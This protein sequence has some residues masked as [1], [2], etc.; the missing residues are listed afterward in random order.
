MD[1]PQ[2]STCIVC[3]K[4][5]SRSELR[6]WAAVR[7]QISQLIANDF[8]DWKDGA[9]IWLADLSKYRHA[10][11]ENL[12]QSEQGELGALEQQVLSSFETGETIAAR[13]EDTDDDQVGFGDR[14]ADH[15][16]RFGGSWAFILSFVGVLTLWMVLNTTAWL[17]DAFDPFPFILLNLVLSCVAALQAPIIMMSQRRQETKDRLRAESDYKVNLKAELEI[18]QLHEKIDFQAARQ[19]ERLVEIQKVQIDLLEDRNQR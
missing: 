7:P 3:H 19:W 13:P 18:R 6:P 5:F 11:V 1:K 12:L 8:E 17:F 10:Y 9:F 16:A 14:M 2:K 4:K 15:V